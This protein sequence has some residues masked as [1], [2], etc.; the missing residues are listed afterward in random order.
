MFS[1]NPLNEKKLKE[2]WKR[3]KDES[4]LYYCFL[5]DGSSIG[6]DSELQQFSL[7][8]YWNKISQNEADEMIQTIGY[9]NEV[10]W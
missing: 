2:T 1:I 5:E 7:E 4:N 10:E 9:Y 8:D 3:D 6:Y